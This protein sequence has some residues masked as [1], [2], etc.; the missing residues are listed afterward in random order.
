MKILA[1]ICEYNPFHK[2]HEYQIKTHKTKY[3]ADAVICLMSGNFVQ[4]GAPALFDKWTR[5]KTAVL[6]GADLVLELP[7]VYACQSSSRFSSGAVKLLDALGCVDYLSFGSECGEIAPL[8][9]AS[10]II[11]SDEFLSLVKE[12]MKQ[13]VSYPKARTNVVKKNFLSLDP[14]LIEK[15]NN[16]LALEYLSAL[17]N[18]KSTITP[19]TLKRNEAFL[20]ASKIREKI[21]NEVN[22]KEFVP[23]SADYLANLPYDKKAFDDIVSYQMRRETMESLRKIADVAEGLEGRFLKF[24]RS[25]FGAEDLADSVKTKRYT[26]TRIDRII[27]NTLLGITDNDTELYPEY[28]RVLAFN[29]KGREALKEIDKKT[30]IPI[31]TKLA[32]AKITNSNFSRI[33]EKDILATDIYSILTNDKRAGKDYLTSPMYIKKL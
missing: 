21:N 32:D 30:K 31:I 14:A 11:S 7:T 20:S 1:I 15:P 18:L 23:E 29:D 24:A 28:A 4:R 12:E 22:I 13:G 8:I 2:G 27:I 3:N 10:S 16:I 33:L 5:A 9:H 17:K 6:S 19:V 26:R 25:T